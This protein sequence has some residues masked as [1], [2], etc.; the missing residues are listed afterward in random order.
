MG[1]RNGH[2]LLNESL[3][4]P[5]LQPT[6]V[7]HDGHIRIFGGQISRPNR[8]ERLGPEMMRKRIAHHDTGMDA[9]DGLVLPRNVHDRAD[10]VHPCG[11]AERPFISMIRRHPL[12]EPDELA[13]RE[14]L[15][16]L[17][18]RRLGRPFDL[19]V[20]RFTLRLHRRAHRH[21]LVGVTLNNLEIERVR[22]TKRWQQHAHVNVVAVH[23]VQQPCGVVVGS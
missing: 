8:I 2:R 3:R 18:R 12:T 10:L 20:P 22:H 5:P 23:V 16:D 9:R 7:E 13:G 6:M 19:A 15:V 21:E 4:P 17:R 1:R 14:Q 11:L